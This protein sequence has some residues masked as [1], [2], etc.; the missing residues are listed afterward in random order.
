MGAP[1]KGEEELVKKLK[2]SDEESDSKD[3]EEKEEKETIEKAASL[4]GEEFR[5]TYARYVLGFA[6]RNNED[7]CNLA[8]QKLARYRTVNT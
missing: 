4:I 6:A 3:K 8:M 7:T 1:K 5:R 2:E